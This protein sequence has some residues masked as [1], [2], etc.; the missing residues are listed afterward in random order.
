MSTKPRTTI[1]VV[2]D[3]SDIGFFLISA[4]ELETPY[5]AIR[6]SDGQEALQIIRTVE[7]SLFLLDYQLPGMDGIELYD[8][9]HALKGQE[10]PPTILITASSSLP[11]DDIE[12]RHLA[13]IKKP[14]DLDELLHRVEELIEDE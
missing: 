2:E 7:P 9:L 5:R 1:L 12:Q 8:Q 11:L 4:I 13:Y 10:T 6:A 14:F 3:D